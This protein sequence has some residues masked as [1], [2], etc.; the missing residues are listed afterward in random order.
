MSPPYSS[1][2]SYFGKQPNKNDYHICDSYYT[3]VNM[4]YIGRF[5][6]PTYTNNLD[7]T[8]SIKKGPNSLGLIIQMVVIGCR[9]LQLE[10]TNPKGNWNS[11]YPSPVRLAKIHLNRRAIHASCIS[12]SFSFHLTTF[13]W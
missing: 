10:K 12:I 7:C 6:S 2:L 11:S 3:L 9:P 8:I 13:A 5:R 1:P 4:P